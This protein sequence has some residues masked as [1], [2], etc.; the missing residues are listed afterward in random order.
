M[1]M[2]TWSDF[3]SCVG[4]LQVPLAV[5][6]GPLKNLCKIHYNRG[7]AFP[8]LAELQVINRVS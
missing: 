1:I 2:F 7:S 3:G 5:S 8:V 6:L 4:K